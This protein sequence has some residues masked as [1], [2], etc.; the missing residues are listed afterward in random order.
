M[1]GGKADGRQLIG[2][3]RSAADN[4]GTEPLATA[5]VDV[6]SYESTHDTQVLPS[7]SGSFCSL[8]FV[9][10]CDSMKLQRTRNANFRPLSAKNR[11]YNNVSVCV[12]TYFYILIII[13][14]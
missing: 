7:D 10:C 5:V 9:V 12:D 11:K 6:R 2:P 13:I 14:Y 3:D 8:C 4:R 1:A